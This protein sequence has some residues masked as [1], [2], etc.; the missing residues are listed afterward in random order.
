MRGP[1][2]RCECRTA[3]ERRDVEVGGVAGAARN[4]HL[5]GQSV[6]RLALLE[7]LRRLTMG[8]EHVARR[9]HCQAC[10]GRTSAPGVHT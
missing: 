6:L 9:L 7:S 4:E 3:V 1:V 10:R 2:W 5:V 8:V